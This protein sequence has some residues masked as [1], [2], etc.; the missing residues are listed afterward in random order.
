MTIQSLLKT[1]LINLYIFLFCVFLLSVALYMQ[2]FMLLEPCPLCIM[3]RIFFGF[4]GLV[5]LAAFIHNP[6]SNKGRLSYGLFSAA[7][8]AGGA[9]FAI[10]QIWL[11]HLPKDQIPSCGPSLSYMFQEFPLSETLAVMF[12]GD[13]NCAEIVWQDPVL[14]MSIPQWSLVGFVVLAGVCVF[15]AFRK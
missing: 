5:A 15:Q 2:Q 1:R 12:T 8:A 14:N 11:Q 10:R 9:G 6:S 13:G 7:F 3:Q 4:T